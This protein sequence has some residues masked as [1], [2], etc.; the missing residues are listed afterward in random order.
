LPAD[1]AFTSDPAPAARRWGA[2]NRPRTPDAG[3][4]PAG[5][6]AP[7]GRG[8]LRRPLPRAAVWTLAVSCVLLVA[9]VLPYLG[10]WH[11]YRGH[12]IGNLHHV[13]LRFDT[14]PPRMDEAALRRHL[15]PAPNCLNDE[16]MGASRICYLALHSANGLPALTLAFFFEAGFVNVA[17]LHVPWWAHDRMQAALTA[18]WGRPVRQGPGRSDGKPQLV[19]TLP[20]GWLYMN[21]SRYLHPLQWS[22]VVWMPRAD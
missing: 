2:L 11:I 5:P 22:A 7:S 14:L 10:A 6:P 19:W 9:A 15:Q 12:F 8:V 4:A 20:N 18:E 21:E 17:F 1:Q 16:R 13:R 3:A